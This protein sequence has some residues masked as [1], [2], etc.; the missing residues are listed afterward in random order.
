MNII[1]NIKITTSSIILAGLSSASLLAGSMS[2]DFKDPK[3]V[4]N[5]QFLLDAPLEQI[6][7]FANGVSGTINFD[8]AHPEKTTGSIIIDAKTITVGNPMMLDHLKGPKWL[9]VNTHGSISF[10]AKSF[11]NVKESAG[12]VS[13]DV[14]GSFTLKGV[15]KEITV[16]VTFDY[17]ADKLGVRM[18]K[19]DL[20]G[21]LLVVRSDF[22]I[23]RSD[24]GIMP[25]QNE[26]K[27]DEK[28]AISLRVVGAHQH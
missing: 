8:P 10:E 1:K 15:T 11:S 22:T 18:N 21:D 12:K 3:G 25:G 17:M 27:V 16:P 6:S 19:K 26:E 4:N 2:F 14:T 24:Y 9:D 28:I 13:A 5:A 20:K 7:G 23:N